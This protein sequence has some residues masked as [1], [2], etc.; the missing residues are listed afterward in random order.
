MAAKRELGLPLIGGIEAEAAVRASAGWEARR[1]KIYEAARDAVLTDSA[2]NGMEKVV[3]TL[4]RGST[5]DTNG[6]QTA[7]REAFAANYQEAVTA[8]QDQERYRARSDA[9]R[10]MASQVKREGSQ[11]TLNWDNAFLEHMAGQ[12]RGNGH[13]VGISEATRRW[14]SGELADQLWAEGAARS[15]IES[16]ADQLLERPN[17]ERWDTP[18]D[19]N[20]PGMC[21]ARSVEIA[22]DENYQVATGI[23][24]YGEALGIGSPVFDVSRAEQIEGTKEWTGWRHEMSI[25][26]QQ[27]G[28][29]ELA[30]LRKF[31]VQSQV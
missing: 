12:D 28:E 14:T 6:R 21:S 18:S 24:Y 31:T 16:Q 8:S 27:G 2:T 10:E 15:F 11:F 20:I 19:T 13:P 23:R 7:W 17:L 4:G 5:L 22:A 1:A 3:S 25:A 29:E 30:Q 9:A 26:R